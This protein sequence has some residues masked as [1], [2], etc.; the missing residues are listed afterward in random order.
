[1]TFIEPL[2]YSVRI[3]DC[4]AAA[5]HFLLQLLSYVTNDYSAR[6]PVSYDVKEHC[7]IKPIMKLANVRAQV[8]IH[9]KFRWGVS[10]VRRLPLRCGSPRFIQLRES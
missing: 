10:S 3:I 7:E 2:Q 8:R 6:A 1:M 9:S 4:V 5:F